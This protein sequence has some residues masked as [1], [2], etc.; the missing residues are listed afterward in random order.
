LPQ[1]IFG[2]AGRNG[3]SITALCAFAEEEFERVN[4]V[5]ALYVFAL[6]DAADRANVEGYSLRNLPQNKGAKLL[7]IP[8]A[9][10]IFLGLYN[11]PYNV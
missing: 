1:K 11:G 7:Y 10:E 2:A 5:V 8:C 4:A 6:G 9:E 3:F